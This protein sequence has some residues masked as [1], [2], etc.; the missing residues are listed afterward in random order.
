M[1]C[2]LT[3]RGG[4]HTHPARGPLPPACA[5]PHRGGGAR[6]LWARGGGSHHA[7]RGSRRT[8]AQHRGPPA[9]AAAGRRA[10]EVSG[11]KCRRRLPPCPRAARGAT[12][13]GGG[14]GCR[15][16]VGRRGGGPRAAS[17][18][19]SGA[20]PGRGD[21]EGASA[22]RRGPR[23]ADAAA[24]VRVVLAGPRRSRRTRPRVYP[25]GG[26]PR[27]PTLVEVRERYTDLDKCWPLRPSRGRIG[28]PSGALYSR[29][30]R[31][32]LWSRGRR[33][34]P[35][36]R[37]IDA[38][39]PVGLRLVGSARAGGGWAGRW[40]PRPPR[41]QGGGSQL[42]REAG[43]AVAG[44]RAALLGPPRSRRTRPRVYPAPGSIEWRTLVKVRERLTDLDQCTPLR[45]SRGLSQMPTG[46]L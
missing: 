38:E 8:P 17:G 3:V 12:L 14:R 22:A 2:R 23:G 24:E 11:G 39:G 19:P 41:H 15:A 30:P 7:R 27:W 20:P 36:P 35:G 9:A 29:R 13:R 26:S 16:R 21:S 46:A 34:R 28:L 31:R 40:A 10:G 44:V 32:Q 37:A 45:T 6:L 5:P 4:A 25:A 33:T 43:G 1:H 18:G 42:A